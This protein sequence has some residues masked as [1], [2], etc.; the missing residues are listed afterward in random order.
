MSTIRIML[1]ANAG[2]LIDYQGQQILIDALHEGHRLYPG[3]S[4][5][6]VQALLDGRLP[7]KDIQALLFTHNHID[8]FSARLALAVL[9]R[10][11]EAAFI[12]DES[13]AA[14]LLQLNQTTSEG[15]DRSRIQ[16]IPWKSPVPGAP[17]APTEWQPSERS[18]F[19]VGA[20]EIEAI[21][22][23]H[24]GRRFVDIANIG[25]LV[26]VG[27]R[28]ILF[29]GD[30][31]ISADNFAAVTRQA[32]PVDAAVV[33]FPYI[34]TGRGQNLVRDVLKPHRLIVVHWP[35]PVRD[36]QQFTVH[37]KRTYEKTKDNLMETFFL[38]KYQDSVEI[39]A[40]ASVS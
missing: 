35:D 8:H 2:I 37:A 13:S 32:K 9:H 26:T 34:A 16:T 22:F 1:I 30:A 29:P 12:S 31:R 17:G 20:F 15:F 19:T 10:H 3:T 38:E 11:P 33:M 18:R 21:S 28:S 36:S 25:F 40:V 14:A 4:P 7:F 23:E 5:E 39:E 27:G 24:E 6:T